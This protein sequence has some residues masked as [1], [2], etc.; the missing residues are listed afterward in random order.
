VKPAG[1]GISTQGHSLADCPLAPHPDS[2]RS[3]RFRHFATHALIPP[4]R[5]YVRYAP[6]VA[7]KQALWDRIVDPYFAWH[8]HRFIARAR[9]G[10]RMSGETTEILQQYLYYFGLWE[11][12]VTRCVANRLQP[13]DVFVD[14]G[15]NI[16]YYSLLA[17]HCV[18]KDGRVVAVEPAPPLFSALEESV[19][20]NGAQ[21]IRCVRAAAS[22]RAGRVMLVAGPEDNTGLTRI[23]ADHGE[24]TAEAV[25]A[26]PLDQILEHDE[27][28]RVRLVKIDVEGAEGAVVAGMSAL[29]EAPL[30]DLEILVELHP[31]LLARHGDSIEQ[32]MEQFRSTGFWPFLI[33]NDYT[34]PALIG[35][36]RPRDPVPVSGSIDHESNVLFTR[37]PN[38]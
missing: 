19:L 30:P 26:R 23:A 4:L 21:N 24:N 13:G 37:R 29:L 35:T 2:S 36:R 9:F 14:V 16:G 22:G 28:E 1:P 10:A 3:A 32:I 20:R 27:L 34:P 8:R 25:E 33:E 11:P 5:S 6:R 38:L 12:S 18:G 17:A 15:A 31:D 7:G